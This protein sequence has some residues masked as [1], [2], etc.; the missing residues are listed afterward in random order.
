MVNKLEWILSNSRCLYGDTSKYHTGPHHKSP[1]ITRTHRT[2]ADSI[3]THPTPPDLTGIPAMINPTGPTATRPTLEDPYGLH[4]NPSG[5][6]WTI[7]NIN[8]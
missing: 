8:K 1:D 6:R 5:L 3:A 2:P 4:R 7:A